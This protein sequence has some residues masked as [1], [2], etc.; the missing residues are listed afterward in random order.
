MEEEK[1]ECTVIIHT[2]DHCSINKVWDTLSGDQKCAY[3]LLWINDRR[4]DV[5]ALDPLAALPKG[6]PQSPYSCPVVRGLAASS[7]SSYLVTW[8]CGGHSYKLKLPTFVRRWIAEFDHG[9]Y[10]Q[11]LSPWA[12][13]SG[14]KTDE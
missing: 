12:K 8:H 4:R 11:L 3:V 10:P 2:L 7:V 9:R 1:E 6:K 13:E 5:L 14:W